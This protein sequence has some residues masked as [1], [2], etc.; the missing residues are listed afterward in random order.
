MWIMNPGSRNSK[1]FCGPD[2]AK[3]LSSRL[4]LKQDIVSPCSVSLLPPEG[5]TEYHKTKLHQLHCNNKARII[6]LL[7]RPVT[8]YNLPDETGD[9]A[10]FF[11]NHYLATYEIQLCLLCTWGIVKEITA[12]TSIS[13]F[14]AASCSCSNINSIS[15]RALC[16]PPLGGK[17][18]TSH[19]SSVLFWLDLGR[20]Y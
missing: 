17:I 5:S 18:Y 13:G 15:L 8:E 6:R 14:R 7:M 20:K 10:A 4:S 1:L 12:V 9:F 2:P 11:S 16:P 3:C 19:S